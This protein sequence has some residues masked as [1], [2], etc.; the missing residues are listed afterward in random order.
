MA[1]K[2]RQPHP[3]GGGTE[4][5]NYAKPEPE[6]AKS[7]RHSS[8]RI[9]DKTWLDA[10]KFGNAVQIAQMSGKAQNID[11]KDQNGMTALMWI[12][13]RCFQM[14]PSK[15]MEA[16]ADVLI[17]DNKGK[18]VFYYA[19]EIPKNVEMLKKGLPKSRILRNVLGNATDSFLFAFER[20]K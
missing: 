7:I 15:I 12:C 11:A 3:Q 4:T 16:G 2:T 8:S 17:K 19:R 6:K 18:T 5:G 20:C 10:A 13:Y 14:L 9:D 1:L